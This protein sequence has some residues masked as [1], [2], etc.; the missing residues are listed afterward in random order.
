[1]SSAILDIKYPDIAEALYK[2]NNLEEAQA[3]Y[4]SS[5]R[6]THNI[7]H[8]QYAAK[9]EMSRR[10]LSSSNLKQLEKDF[11]AFKDHMR[12]WSK[13]T[14]IQLYLQRR[15]KDFLGLNAK[16]RLFLATGQN[17]SMINDLLG[18]RIILK[19]PYPDNENS[20]RQCYDVIN[21][22]MRFFLLNRN[23]ML[24]EAEPRNGLEI[25]PQEAEHLGIIVPHKHFLL[26]GFENNVKDYV[27]HPKKNGYQGLHTL[28]STP[29]GLIFEVQ[30]KTSFMDILADHG[31]GNHAKY[32][33]TKYEDANLGFIDFSKINMPGFR[34]LPSGEVYDKIG[35]QKSIDPFNLLY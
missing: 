31:S 12:V 23:C 7:F 13:E 35:L 27:L 2:A 24:M 10:M 33:A 6:G 16:I 17:L 26:S 1:M 34:V 5:L 19:T 15:Q 28:I 32:K 20:I 25:T 18:F 9:L 30:V 14:G 8:S 3:L 22:T 29:K 4:V 11:I 21:E